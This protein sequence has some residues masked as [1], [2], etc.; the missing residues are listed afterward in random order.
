[1][2][3]FVIIQ[4]LFLM[5]LA[6]SVVG[7][8]CWQQS[9]PSTSATIPENTRV[10]ILPGFGN[11]SGDYTMDGSLVSS[12]LS[13]GWKESQVDVLPVERSDWLQVFLRG[14][15]DLEFWRGNASPDRPAFR[16]Y[17]ERISDKVQELNEGE[18]IIL[19]GHSAGGWLARAAVGYGSEDEGLAIDLDK[20]KGIVTLGAPN[21]PPPPSVMDMTRGALRITNEK[22][23]GAYHAPDT[24]YVT[25]IG[26]AVQGKKQERSSPF[27]RTTIDG[28]AFNSYEA[29]CGDGTTVG[30]GVVPLCAAH[31]DGATQ[32][33]LDGVFHSINRPDQWYGSENV[34]DDWHNFVLDEMKRKQEVFDPMKLFSR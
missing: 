33:N 7:F 28:F 29:V 14:A 19:M 11:E 34:L 12:L 23:P 24:F 1:M 2:P 10:L 22:F 17:L 4:A 3:R 32:L 16:W 30:D 21:L 27:E 31:V 13:R 25:V 9:M 26:N 8:A 15:L 20:I 6:H 5:Q 18:S